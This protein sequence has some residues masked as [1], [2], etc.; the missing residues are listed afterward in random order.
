MTKS[1]MP[2]TNSWMKK[3]RTIYEVDKMTLNKEMANN[4]F[5]FSL[6]QLCC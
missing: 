5:Y 4:R 6:P 3:S 2:P 1:A